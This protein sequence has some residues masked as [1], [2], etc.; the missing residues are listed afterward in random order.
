MRRRWIRISHYLIRGILFLM[1]I[2]VVIQAVVYFVN[3]I[4]VES[5]RTAVEYWRGLWEVIT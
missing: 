2:G 1:W 4:R 3:P 5:Y